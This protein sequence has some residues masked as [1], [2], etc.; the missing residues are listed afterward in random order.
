MRYA[1]KPHQTGRIDSTFEGRTLSDDQ[2][3]RRTI[4][5]TNFAAL[6]H[7]LTVKCPDGRELNTALTH[8]EIAYMFAVAAISREP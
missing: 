8:L 5:R 4:V 2:A 7:A 6:S 3:E 1:P